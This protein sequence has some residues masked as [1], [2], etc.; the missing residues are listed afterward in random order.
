ML[1][2]R[3]GQAVKVTFSRIGSVGARFV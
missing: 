1:E 2:V 3:A